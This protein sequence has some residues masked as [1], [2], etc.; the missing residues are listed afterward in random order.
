[1][2]RVFSF[3]LIF[4][5]LFSSVSVLA[6]SYAFRL[7]QEEKVQTLRSAAKKEI[8]TSKAV[9]KITKIRWAIQKPNGKWKVVSRLKMFAQSIRT[10][11]GYRIWYR[12]GASPS[13]S[14]SWW[15]TNP[16]I[17]AITSDGVVEAY[18]KGKTKLVIWD[19]ISRKKARLTLTVKNPRPTT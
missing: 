18:A 16:C 12:R 9:K 14:L 19:K 17:A 1:M 2:R 7:F 11:I 5:L 6:E 8:V 13:Y 4:V 10:D 15:S 3:L